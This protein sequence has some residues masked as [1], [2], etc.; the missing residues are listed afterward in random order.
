MG[1]CFAS[2]FGRAKRPRSYFTGRYKDYNVG[3]EF[4]NLI[5]DETDVDN[6]REVLSKTEKDHL[7][8]KRFSKLVEDQRK[9]D[10]EIDAQLL[11][12]EE[13]TRL[14][15]E[16]YIAAKK[17]AAKIAK[18]AK[19]LEEQKKKPISNG[20]VKSW[21]GDNGDWSMANEEDED[22]F[23]SF[24]ETVNAR[25]ENVRASVAS[26]SATNSHTPHFHDA[27]LVP[28]IT[29]D[30]AWEED[31]GIR[32]VMGTSVSAQV[33][34]STNHGPFQDSTSNLFSSQ[35][36]DFEWEADFVSAEM[37]AVPTAS[38]NAAGDAAIKPKANGQVNFVDTKPDKKESANK[39]SFSIT[40]EDDDEILDIS[41][42]TI[43]KLPETKP[44][45]SDDSRGKGTIEANAFDIDIDKF[46]EELDA[47][48]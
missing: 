20:S 17:Q 11:E 45:T 35:K 19:L 13:R 40:D 24:L 4:D 30:M 22:D 39:N 42:E 38:V 28:V 5:E 18:Q 43:E 2:L 29:T 14:E 26:L 36:S 7:I 44:V 25:S 6:N 32:G 46:L 47:E 48:L 10:A 31:P 27:L 8:N 16:A 1:N 33:V 34:T 37:Q 23:D 41:H 12:E 21:V 3:V 9:V 15:E